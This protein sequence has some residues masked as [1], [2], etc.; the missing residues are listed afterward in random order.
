MIPTQI[1]STIVHPSR[2]SR[3]LLALILPVI[4]TTALAEQKNPRPCDVAKPRVLPPGAPKPSDVIMRSLRLHPAGKNDPHDTM[5]ALHDFHVTRLEWAYITDKPFIAK[6]KASGRLFGGAAAAPSYV[7]PKD[8]PNWLG[9]VVVKNLDGKPIIAPWKRTWKP[10]LW[11]CVNN[12]EL[13][14]GYMQYL[15]AYV[16]A[17]AEVMQRDEPGGN[18][19][20]TRWGGCFCPYCMA[21]FRTYLAKETS[22]DDR[23]RLNIENLETFDYRERL[24]KQG[25]PVGDAFAKWKGGELKRLFEDFQMA[26]TLAFHDRTRGSLDAHAGRRVPFSCNNSVRSWTPLQLAYDWAFGELS[27]GHARPEFLLQAMRTAAEHGRIQ[28]VTMPKKGDQNDM[29]AWHRRTR[30]TIATAYACGGLCMVP[31]DVFMPKDAPRYFGTPQQYADLFGFIRAVARYL[32]EYE[33][34]AVAGAGLQETRYGSKSPVR[35]VGGTGQ[36]RAFVRAIPARPDAPIVIHL[37]EWANESKPF[38]LELR[39]ATFSAGKLPEMT[40]HVPSPYDKE[41]HATADRTNDYSPL[42]KATRLT[43]TVQADYTVVSIPALNPWG[44]VVVDSGK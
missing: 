41:V 25:A 33:D 5:K 23:R 1:P 24:R 44:I 39:S 15:K 20:A 19:T 6:V 3:L 38:T 34:A 27:Y 21:A 42:S 4:A 7:K 26:A 9:N 32:D 31:W 22:P 37:V 28:V 12:P 2:R 35:L 36:V 29:P 8:D 11:G 16:D 43:P 14:R 18:H 17:G 40:L 10:T 30:Q 13:E